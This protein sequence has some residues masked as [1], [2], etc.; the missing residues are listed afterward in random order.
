MLLSSK[1]E[2][3]MNNS[4]PNTL[5]E[6]FDQS[7]CLN[8]VEELISHKSKEVSEFSQEFIEEYFPSLLKIAEPLCK[9]VI[10]FNFS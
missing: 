9:S 3:D 7:G 10:N 4:L 8:S 2:N 5:Q 6:I 1:I